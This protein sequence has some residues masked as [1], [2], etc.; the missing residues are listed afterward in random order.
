MSELLIRGRVSSVIGR[1]GKGVC[2]LQ[3]RTVGDSSKGDQGVE[4]GRSGSRSS[5]QWF[6]DIRHDAVFPQAGTVALVDLGDDV[7][8]LD[9]EISDRGVRN[10]GIVE[11]ERVTLL[12]GK[13]PCAR[14]GC[15]AL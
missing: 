11:R 7:E 4:P 1:S 6:T 8:G 15:R 5:L 12:P 13:R 2:S 3:K 14:I 9:G 10:H